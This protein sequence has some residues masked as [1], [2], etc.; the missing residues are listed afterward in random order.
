MHFVPIDKVEP[1]MITV[2]RIYDENGVLMLNSNKILT[3]YN[4]EKIKNLGYLGL[5]IYDELSSLDSVKDIIDEKTRRQA[6]KSL[7]VFN[8]DAVTF[9]ANSI[10]NSLQKQDEICVELQELSNFHDYTYQHCI[11]VAI[12]SATIGIGLGLNNEQLNNLT[13]AALLHDIGKMDIPTEI[14][15]K[16]AKLTDEEFE[17]IK[18]HSNLGYEKVKDNY[19]IS[20]TIKV[21]IK[22]H[23]E[24]Q[25]GSGY[26]LHLKGDEIH[27]FAKIIHVADVYDALVSKRSYKKAYK[28]SEAIE[29]LMANVGNMFDLNV[30]ITFLK[31]IAVYP[32]GTKVVLS[33]GQEA[34]VIKQNIGVP[35]RPVVA[36]DKNNVIDLCNDQ[37][38]LSIVIKD[39]NL[40][41]EYENIFRI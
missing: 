5:Y 31:Y 8:L 6:I 7:K 21:A 10:V 18:N 19:N 29:Y 15:D 23:H 4:I 17:I 35:L 16:P 13:T 14:L 3:I 36:L 39:S 38:S 2:K 9:C 40:E 32:I 41:Q 27:I 25:D 11:N 24:N 34:Q 33:T 37:D 28:P 26:P 1:G 22:E 12:L 20:S 30:V